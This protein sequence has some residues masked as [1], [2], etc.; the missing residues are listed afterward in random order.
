[1]ADKDYQT[2]LIEHLVDQNKAILEYVG[3]IPGIKRDIVQLKEDV[4]ELKSDMK[5]VK[6]AV[7][8]LSQQVANHER[9]ITQL[10]AA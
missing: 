6:A 9:R 4:A 5:I 10:E 3:E 1:M 7:T 2:V 8:D